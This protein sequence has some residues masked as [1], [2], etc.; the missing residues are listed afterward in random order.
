MSRSKLSRRQRAAAARAAAIARSSREPAKNNFL[1]DGPAR[2]GALLWAI[3]LTF[4]YA[5]V[6]DLVLNR[7]ENRV[8]AEAL[9][10]CI[11][12]LTTRVSLFYARPV[13]SKPHHRTAER[14]WMKIENLEL[15]GFGR[16]LGI[17]ALSL[18][19]ILSAVPVNAVEPVIAAW[20][21][22]KSNVGLIPGMDVDLRGSPPAYRFQQVSGRIERSINKKKPGD[23]KAVG[24]VRDALA[25]I[26]ENIRLPENVSAAA[27]LE[28]A[29]LQ[30]Y[31]SLSTIGAQDP[32]IL[33]QVTSGNLPEGIPAVIGAGVDKTTLMMPPWATGG[34]TVMGSY[35][36]FFS[37]FSVISFA[38]TADSLPLPFAIT[39]GDNTAV[40]F[41]NMRVQGFAQDIG[42]LTWT[43]V[44]FVGCLIS[45]HGQPLRMGNV[46]F[47]GCTFE[48]ST[49]GKG[50]ELLDYLSRHQGEPVSAYVGA[51][52]Y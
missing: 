23:P 34:F 20:I 8:S 19:L 14:L 36:K 28:L 4:G 30:S 41:N 38:R 3:F 24:E 22:K 6:N 33:N 16:T 11:V 52:R 49:N 12:T 26:V 25:R 32:R 51:S 15:Q 31:E 47:I 29:Y 1:T 37:D 9:V 7:P 35:P 27:Q 45:Y 13:G 44:T 48:R 42:N 17:I 46:R 50:Q 43:N 18:I 2:F 21:L 10:V 5:V 39:T 40:I